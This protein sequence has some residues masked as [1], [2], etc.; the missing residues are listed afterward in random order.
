MGCD[1][2]SWNAEGIVT[3]FEETNRSIPKGLN[4]HNS[5]QNYAIRTI[6]APGLSLI[7]TLNP[8]EVLQLREKAAELFQIVE[9]MG[10]YSSLDTI[11]EIRDN[12]LEAV[13]AYWGNIC[14]Y[15]RKTRPLLTQH[16]TKI[17]IFTR[18]KLPNFPPWC[19]KFISFTI[20]LGF[21][22]LRKP[23]LNISSKIDSLVDCS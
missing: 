23:L 22:L 17:G 12:Y 10:E 11:L 3:G 19:T 21:D 13:I 4:V 9:F 8:N 7:A 1:S 14:S 20:N 6:E 18:D 2:S 5:L 15:L 16:R